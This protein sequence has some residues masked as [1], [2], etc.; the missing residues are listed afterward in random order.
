MRDNITTRFHML[1]NKNSSPSNRLPILELLVK[2]EPHLM[3]TLQN[4][5]SALVYPPKLNDKMLLLNPQ[6][7]T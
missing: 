6:L 1:P 7:R 3:Q 4:I 2:G 5:S